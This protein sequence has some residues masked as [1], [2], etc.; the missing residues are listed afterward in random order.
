MTR[1]PSL[2]KAIGTG[3][4]LAGAAALALFMLG[5]FLD[6]VPANAADAYATEFALY[7][8]AAI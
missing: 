4:A 1:R 6:P 2:L 5:G 3:F 8:E 7:V